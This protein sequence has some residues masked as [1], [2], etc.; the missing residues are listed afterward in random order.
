MKRSDLR[1]K[2]DEIANKF[3]QNSKIFSDSAWELQDRLK[4]IRILP[5][6]I[7]EIGCRTGALSAYLC[8]QIPTA[9]FVAI[10][11]SKNMVSVA[12]RK[13][14]Q[15]CICFAVAD[16]DTLPIASESFDLIV[17]NLSSSYYA[18]EDFLNE[19]RRLLKHDGVLMFTMLG[20]GSFK[21]LN[22]QYD[23][24]DMHTIGDLLMS[25]GFSDSVVDVEKFTNEFTDW[26]SLMYDLEASGLLFENINDT[27]AKGLEKSQSESTN[28]QNNYQMSYEIVYGL[29]W[30]KDTFGGSTSVPFFSN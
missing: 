26:Q 11:E 16:C 25:T 2:L 1:F 27:L 3:E 12:N 19:C 6:S 23:F 21:E 5:E 29:A 13:L 24:Y 28:E 30:R 8:E 15:K 18:P 9:L 7:L 14:S 22:V 20:L 10:D 4:D 17:S